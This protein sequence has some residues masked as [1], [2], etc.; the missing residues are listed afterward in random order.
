MNE[1]TKKII[2]KSRVIFVVIVAL[3][4]HWANPTLP[5]IQFLSTHCKVESEA[6]VDRFRSKIESQNLFLF[7]VSFRIFLWEIKFAQKYS[8]VVT[9]WCNDRLFRMK[10]NLVN[11]TYVTKQSIFSSTIF[12]IFLHKQT[13]LCDQVI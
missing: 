8:L 3:H 1:R 7:F 12:V 11:T 9:A 5:A 2:P 13:N 4:L 10:Y 6:V